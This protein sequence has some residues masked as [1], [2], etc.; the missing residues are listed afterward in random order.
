VRR[1]HLDALLYC[2]VW[3]AL[4][5]YAW[6]AVSHRA[7]LLASIGLFLI[8]MPT[9][10]ILLSRTG[11]FRLERTIRWAILAVAAIAVLSF[12]DLSR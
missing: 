7:G 9:S 8:V 12:A 6:N 3:A 10:L 4:A 11:S 2:I 1:L 5:I